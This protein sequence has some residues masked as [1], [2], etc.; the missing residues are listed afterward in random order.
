MKF[1][2]NEVSNILKEEI[3]QY[4]TNLGISKVGR[5]V[6]VGDGIAR[7]YGLD[8]VMA[9]EM[10]E[11]ENGVPGEVFNLDE[12]SVG[13]VIYGKFAQVREGSGRTCHGKTPF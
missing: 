5:V 9:G 12:N 7:I 3:K 4:K 11:F 13:A 2:I 1:N 6:E 10:L 8:D